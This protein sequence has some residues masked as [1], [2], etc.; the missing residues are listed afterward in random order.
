MIQENI[1]VS[2]LM[3]AYNREN[4]IETALKGVL[5]QITNFPIEIIIG[6]DC[7]TD[8]TL[9]V[10]ERYKALYPKQIKLIANEQNLGLQR[11]YIKSFKAA[12]GKYIAICDPDDYWFNKH[13]L[14]IQVDILEKHPE[15][16]LCFHRVL[17]YYEGDKSKSFSNGGQKKITTIVDLATANYI[18][19]VSCIFRNHIFEL[20]EGFEGNALCD[21]SFH[22]LCAEKGDLIYLPKVMAVYRKH[23]TGIF[24]G[25][26][27]E[28][29][30]L[31]AMKVRRFMIHLFADRPEVVKNL[32]SAE[33]AILY[34][35]WTFC[36]E[37]ND[38]AKAEK[39]WN[40]LISS[41]TPWVQQKLLNSGSTSM[42]QRFKE[43][44]FK[45][46]SNIRKQVSKL[47]PLPTV[48]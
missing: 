36:L 11:N 38:H 30:L 19:N 44:G 34:A 32:R 15:Y 43:S 17:N 27:R 13:K 20:P 23:G 25:E 26:N 6:E 12:T 2:V 40:E 33:S 7:S 29:A 9:A 3:I 35:L 41:N 18:S 21:Y 37:I 45:C 5:N 42:K 48:K 8:G 31:E 47:L 4:Y 24:S 16:S 22:M 14:Q 39:Y 46:L 28:K 10:C 1:M